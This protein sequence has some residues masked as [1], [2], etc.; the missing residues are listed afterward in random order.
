MEDVHVTLKNLMHSQRT[1]VLQ[2]RTQGQGAIRS[3]NASVKLNLLGIEMVFIIFKDKSRKT[4]DMKPPTL[5]MKTS[6]YDIFKKPG[7]IIPIA[8]TF[9]YVKK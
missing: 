3:P 4:N 5:V 7:G 9:P 6:R 2:L 8:V 1:P